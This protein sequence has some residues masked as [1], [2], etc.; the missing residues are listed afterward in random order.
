MWKNRTKQLR[1]I[2]GIEGIYYDTIGKKFVKP[3][4]NGQTPQTSF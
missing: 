4:K 1:K 2:N 3:Y